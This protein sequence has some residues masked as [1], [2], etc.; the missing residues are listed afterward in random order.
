[1]VQDD[2]LRKD[3][4]LVCAQKCGKFLERGQTST[5]DGQVDSSCETHVGQVLVPAESALQAARWETFIEVR[6]RKKGCIN[7]YK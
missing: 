2:W 4:G 1:M 7:L 3:K 6:V 5:C